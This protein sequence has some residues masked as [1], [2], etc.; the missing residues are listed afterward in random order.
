M[1]TTPQIGAVNWTSEEIKAAIP[2]F[3]TLYH[4]RPIKDNQGGMRAPHLLATWFMLKKLNPKYV[5]ESGVWKGQSTWLIEQ[6]LPDA[7]IFSI[8]INLAVR[9]YISDKVQYFN[10]DFF[11]IDWSII[12]N[13]SETLLFFDDHQNALKR[14]KKGATLGFKHYLFEDNYPAKYGDCY[15]LKKAFQHAGFTPSPPKKTVKQLIKSLVKP[16]VAKAE[17]IPANEEDSEYLRRVLEIYYEFPPVFKTPQ[18]RWGDDWEDR[19]YP[20]VEPLYEEVESEQLR[21]FK[22]EA[23]SYNWICY[24]KLK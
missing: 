13:K 11:V 18:T 20:T 10:K 9:E 15:S 1:K 24:A 22:E 2:E 21:V 6:T 19:N 12:P 16:T 5:I 8:D 4:Q 23:K 17:T 14:I 7:T 3:L